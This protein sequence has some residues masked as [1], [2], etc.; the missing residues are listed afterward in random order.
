MASVAWV[1]LTP[2]VL[3][4]FPVA[5]LSWILAK[6]SGRERELGSWHE[7]ES[8]K[9]M[10]CVSWTVMIGHLNFRQTPDE[11]PI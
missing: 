5:L 7:L 2:L 10:S 9:T 6:L 3:I 8:E 4:G 1:V 11:S